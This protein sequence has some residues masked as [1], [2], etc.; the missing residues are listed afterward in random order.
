MSGFT[1]IMQKKGR[2]LIGLDFIQRIRGFW[3][4]Y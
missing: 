2:L 4:E 3:G 1:K